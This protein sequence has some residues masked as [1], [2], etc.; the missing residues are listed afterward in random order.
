MQ[1][2]WFFAV[3]GGIRS[4]FGALPLQFPIPKGLNLSAQG[5]EAR[6]TLGEGKRIFNPERVVS[7]FISICYS[8]LS[9]LG[10]LNDSTQGRPSRI[11]PTLG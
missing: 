11:G 3:F 7:W 8:T 6:A 4:V 10:N 5:C 1:L 9:G 2:I